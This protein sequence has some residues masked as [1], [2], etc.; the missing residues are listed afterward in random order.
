MDHTVH[1]YLSWGI[2]LVL[3]H[4]SKEARRFICKSQLIK[5][6]LKK[7]Y[8]TVP[9]AEFLSWKSLN[10]GNT[11]TKIFRLPSK[12][13]FLPEE[14]KQ[15]SEMRKLYPMSDNYFVV[16]VLC[17]EH[18]ERRAIRQM[19]VPNGC[20]RKLNLKRLFSVLEAFRRLRRMAL[21]N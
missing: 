5:E 14:S 13:F 2:F 8:K 16:I 1:S 17:L 10:K 4:T 20:C 11:S 12:R 3:N 19:D 21:P 9:L 15:C 6:K 7:K 18:F